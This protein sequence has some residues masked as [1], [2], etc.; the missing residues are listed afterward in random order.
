M[1]KTV[2]RF[3]LFIFAFMLLVWFHHQFVVAPLDYANKDFMSLWTGGRAVLNGLDPYDEAVWGPLRASYGSEWFPDPSAPFP[4]WTFVVMLPFA[5]LPLSWAAAAWLAF[6][7]VLLGTSALWLL[8]DV[9]P[10][11][12]TPLEIGLLALG[13]F[14]S[15]ITIL[16][17]INGQMTFLLVAVLVLFLLFLT[18]RN[19]LVAGV[20]LSFIILKPNPF[21]LFAP[22]IGL[23]L[24][25]QRRWRVIGGSLSG[26]LFMFVATWLIQ[27]GWLLAW[28]SVR[29]KTAVVTITPTLWGLAAEIAPNY[30]FVVGM[31][32]VVMTTAVTA[33]YIFTRPQ[34]SATA[35]VSLA[36][37]ASLLITPY[38]WAYEH[39]LLFIA[40]LWLFA[41]I[42]S[43]RMA[44]LT[45]VGVAWLLPWIMFAIAAIRIND[46]F[47]FV[48]PLLTLF[49]TMWVSNRYG[50]IAQA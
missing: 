1:L 38:G 42:K 48:V 26:V 6:S 14:A 17:L 9:C 40:W 3:F 24:I 47:G 35:V 18:R 45:W 16:V 33:Y 22:L 21:I 20:M 43:R 37:S 7:E 19:L 10:H 34:L 36:L 49:L 12:P 27:P 44:Q 11:R 41:V 50:E 4:L 13:M 31:V 32:L 28:A 30:W 2:S 39:A 25:L 15:I 29:S 23:W 46:A 8:R 5:L